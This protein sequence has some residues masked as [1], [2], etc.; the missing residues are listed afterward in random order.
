[1]EQ[2]DK[3]LMGSVINLVNKQLILGNNINIKS[4]I[5]LGGLNS[6]INFCEQQFI[7]T[8]D[9]TYTDKIKTLEKT[10]LDL[11]S[12]CEDI[13]AY[14]KRIE[15]KMTFFNTDAEH[16]IALGDCFNNITS[17]TPVYLSEGVDFVT[18]TTILFLDKEKTITFVGSTTLPLTDATDIIIN[19][20]ILAKKIDGE[21]FKFIGA[22]YSVTDA[23]LIYTEI[24]C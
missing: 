4:L 24:N 9:N 20:Y 2:K 3:I 23:G 13:C 12:K 6:S 7:S 17:W 5:L 16:F 18:G 19:E 8:Q 1:M 21:L 14:N 11:S 22:L 15:S 10:R